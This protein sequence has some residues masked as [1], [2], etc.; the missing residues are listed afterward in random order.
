MLNMEINQQADLPS[1]EAHIRKQLGFVHRID[2][3]NALNL[4]N[5]Q[6]FDDEVDPITE[7][8]PFAFENNGKPDLAF[9][10]QVP[11][12]KLMQQASLVRAFEQTR[13]KHGVNFHR[14]GD[15]LMCDVVYSGINLLRSGGHERAI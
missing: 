2:C 1:A 5:D 8:N 10:P 7:V 9:H 14:G 15:D 4:D 13:P 3:F 6:A 11:L 12:S